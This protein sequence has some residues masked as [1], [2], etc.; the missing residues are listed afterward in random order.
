MYQDHYTY[1]AIFSYD[2]DGISVEFPDLPG[3]LTCAD[4]SSTAIS[5]AKEAL[6]VHLIG[7]EDDNEEVPTPSDIALIAPL[8]PSQAIILV[9]VWMPIYKDKIKYS[10]VKKTLTIPKW[11]NDLAEDNHIN[12]SQLLQ[13]SIK[14]QLGLTSHKG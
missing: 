10:S 4:N 11:L 2:A 12:F 3:C 14:D 8:E 1:P 6:A 13:S 7:I 5:R 9:D